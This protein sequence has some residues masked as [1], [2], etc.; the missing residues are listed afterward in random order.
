LITELHTFA[1]NIPSVLVT[2]NLNAISPVKLA[3]LPLVV[4]VE[5]PFTGDELAHALRK[6]LDMGQ[7]P[8]IPA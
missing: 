4:V 3:E 5:K 8:K 7:A 2:G 1:P 6:A